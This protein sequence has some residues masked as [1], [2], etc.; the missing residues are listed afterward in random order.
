M[1]AYDG[2]SYIHDMKVTAL[3]PDDLVNEV[4][5]LA[6]GKNTTESLIIALREWSS[7]QKLKR[8]RERV[9]QHPLD[10]SEGY[11]AATARSLNRER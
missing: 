10:F 2:S 1:L 8:L 3:I 4:K 9:R 7:L 11:S 5:D 6:H